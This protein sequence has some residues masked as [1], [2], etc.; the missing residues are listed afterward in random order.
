MMVGVIHF[1]VGSIEVIIPVLAVG[2][3]G[4]GVQNMGFI[5]ACFGLGTVGNISIPVAT[6]FYGMLLT[7]FS[8]QAITAISGVVLLPTSVFAYFRY[9]KTAKR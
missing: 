4:R 9:I 5:Q 3:K 6:L 8:H 1:F 7:Y 2:L